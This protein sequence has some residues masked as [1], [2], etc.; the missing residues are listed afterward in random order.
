MGGG[1][2]GGSACALGWNPRGEP[3]ASWHTSLLK[4]L[5]QHARCP[6]HDVRIHRAQGSA[7]CH[8]LCVSQ[9]C[10]STAAALFLNLAHFCSRLI[11]AT[12]IRKLAHQSMICNNTV[13]E[14]RWRSSS[15]PPSSP[16][17]CHGITLWRYLWCPVTHHL[18]II[19]GLGLWDARSRWEPLL[20]AGVLACRKQRGMAGQL[21]A[22]AVPHHMFH[23]AAE[24]SD[25]LSDLKELDHVSMFCGHQHI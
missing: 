17:Y 13:V 8:W 16:C 2:P 21:A 23:G 6:H 19:Q 11:E 24:V 18:K 10:L 15:S 20:G 22:V 4:L 5:L 1:T 14:C 3:R 9:L 7:G 12:F 25:G